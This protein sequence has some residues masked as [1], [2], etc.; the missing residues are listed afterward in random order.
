MFWKRRSYIIVL[1]LEASGITELGIPAV[2]VCLARK[3]TIH[4]KETHA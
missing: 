2:F 4:L 3:V 1:V